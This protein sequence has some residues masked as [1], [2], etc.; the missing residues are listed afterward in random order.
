VVKSCDVRFIED[1]RFATQKTQEE[2]ELP[3]KSI[4]KDDEPS[5]GP[6]MSDGGV[7]RE[8]EDDTVDD[9]D[10]ETSSDGERIV[11]RHDSTLEEQ[12][13]DNEEI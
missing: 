5:N 8:D 1:P 2:V 4:N 3:L 13:Q 7:Q 10:Y 12:A 11:E 9:T 6:N